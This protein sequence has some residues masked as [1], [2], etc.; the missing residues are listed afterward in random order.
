MKAKNLGPRIMNIKEKKYMLKHD[1]EMPIGFD[2]FPKSPKRGVR[3]FV[4]GG[5]SSYFTYVKKKILI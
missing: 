3:I 1:G 5:D 2:P 4:G